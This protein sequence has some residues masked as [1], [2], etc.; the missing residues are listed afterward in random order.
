MSESG[1]LVFGGGVTWVW[2]LGG[3]DLCRGSTVGG[4]DVGGRGTEGGGSETVGLCSQR[5]GMK[6]WGSGK[7]KGELWTS[8]I[9]PLKRVPGGMVWFA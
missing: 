4:E 3:E 9:E 1:V 7:M 6:A 5:S 2:V 8:G